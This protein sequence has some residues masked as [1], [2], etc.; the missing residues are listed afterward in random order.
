MSDVEAHSRGKRPGPWR[1]VAVAAVGLIAVTYFWLAQTYFGA[2]S[3]IPAEELPGLAL[4][5]GIALA[6]Q[7]GAMAAARRFITPMAALFGGLNTF[8]VYGVLA[9]GVG[10]LPLAVQAAIWLGVGFL[11]FAVLDLLLR[12]GRLAR[13][14]LIA[15]PLLVLT[16][17]GI[18]GAV[19][20]RAPPPEEAA[21]SPAAAPAADRPNIY[22]LSYDSLVPASL[23]RKYM[24]IDPPAYLGVIARHGGRMLPNTFA[25]AVPTKFSLSSVLMLRANVTDMDNVVNGFRNAPLRRVLRDSGY[26]TTFTFELSFFGHGK[27]PFLDHY[28]I[29]RPYSLCDFI[30]GKR[31]AIGFFGYC[32]AGFLHPPRQTATESYEDYSFRQFRQVVETASDRPQFYMEHVLTPD[33]TDSDYDG[34]PAQKA[35]FVAKYQRGSATAARMLDRALTEIEAKDPGA[36]VFVYGDHGTFT[37]RQVDFEKD[38]KTFVTDRYGTVGAI[39]NADHC[40]PYIQAPTGGRFHTIA[41]IASGIAQCVT[42]GHPKPL[43]NHEYGRIDQISRNERF[44][45]YVYE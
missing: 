40:L 41:Q 10:G 26:E 45:D 13:A 30:R 33:H 18:R 17:V 2:R 23:A 34:S 29:H 9:P 22:F 4:I 37:S 28:N 3:D 43:P 12:N 20:L 24:D 14:A 19:E 39:F 44:A 32:K 21:A 31:R 38:P 35:A 11:Y 15:L 25:E 36:I 27:G 42:A 8:A 7:V 5:T 1:A 6:I 16:Y